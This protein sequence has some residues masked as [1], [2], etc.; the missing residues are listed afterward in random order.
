MPQENVRVVR[1]FLD[2]ARED[3]TAWDI[4]D[5]DVVWEAGALAIPD[6][7]ATSRGPD[8]V[9]GNGSATCPASSILKSPC[10]QRVC[11]LLES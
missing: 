3:P 9:R 5:E 8:G 11:R 7:P 6:L 10:T 4:F 1:S 2:H